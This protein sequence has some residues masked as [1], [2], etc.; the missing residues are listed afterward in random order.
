M[1]NSSSRSLII[2]ADDFGLVPSVTK[3]ILYGISKGCI[4]ETNFIATSPYC[5]EA[6]LLAKQNQLNNMGIHLNLEIGYSCYD[7]RDLSKKNL[8][9]GTPEFYTWV[10]KEFFSQCEFLIAQDIALTHLTYH[11]NIIIDQ[12]MCEIIAKLAMFYNIPVRRLSNERLND[13]LL[14][15]GIKMPEKRIVNPLG[16]KYSL[17]YLQEELREA[18][19]CRLVEVICHPGYMSQVLRQMS[20]LNESR[21]T[22][23]KLFTDFKTTC[24]IREEG[25]SLTDYSIFGDM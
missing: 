25:Y 2:S 18:A 17:R 6:A 24:M 14:D 12:R 10:E 3:G 9:V 1:K 23:L 13:Y 11:K 19:Q 5:Q 7:G 22:E 16:V 20:S 21:P 15:Y 8:E 4:T